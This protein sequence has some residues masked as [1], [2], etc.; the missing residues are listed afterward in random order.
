MPNLIVFVMKRIVIQLS[1][2]S[3]ENWQRIYCFIERCLGS[4]DYREDDFNTMKNNN[5][6]IGIDDDPKKYDVCSVKDEGIKELQYGA[7]PEK[8]DYVFNIIYVKTDE[9]EEFSDFTRFFL[10]KKKYSERITLGIDLSV[11][12]K[13]KFNDYKF[14]L[15]FFFFFIKN[16]QPKLGYN[17]L[18]IINIEG[19]ILKANAIPY[20]NDGNEPRYE[21][22]SPYIFP[23]I[24]INNNNFDIFETLDNPKD[25]RIKAYIENS[26]NNSQKKKELK[27]KHIDTSICRSLFEK[28]FLISYLTSDSKAK[29]T[30]IL[31]Y[32]DNIRELVQNIIFH[33]NEQ[34]G[35]LYIVFNKKNKVSK[36]WHDKILN[37]NTY[38]DNQRFVEI[39]VF[40]Y[41]KK[42]ITDTFSLS[43]NNDLF[44]ARLCLEDFLN[45][46]KILPDKADYISM[47]FAAHL[48]IKSFVSSVMYHKGVFCVESNKS[49]TEK[50]SIYNKERFENSE[51]K[52]I[53]LSSIS[54]I[55]G[56]HYEIILPPISKS[57]T[58][59][60]TSIGLQVTSV[61]DVLK[62]RLIGE[63]GNS[64]IKEIELEIKQYSE[65][66]IDNDHQSGGVEGENQTP[67]QKEEDVIKDYGKQILNIAGQYLKAGSTSVAINI[68]KSSIDIVSSNRFLKLLAYIQPLQ[69]HPGCLI[70]T[71]LEDEVI[72]CL[73]RL[74]DSFI[75]GITEKGQPIWS[76]NHPIVL[77]GKAGTT[78]IL[79]GK[80][81]EEMIYVNYGINLLYLTQ[82]SFPENENRGFIMPDKSRTSILDKL[83]VPYD[84][85]ICS[86]NSDLPTFISRV[87]NIL[88]EPI[89][90]GGMGCKVGVPTKIGSKLYVENYYEC[91]FLFQ[92]NFFTDRFAY[93]IAKEIIEKLNRNE[94]DFI[95]KKLVLIGYNP[96]S[97]PL[98]ERVKDY[99][100]EC[101]SGAITDIIIAKEKDKEKGLEFK[102]SKKQADSFLT[103]QYCFITIVPIASTLSTTDKIIA[104]FN[105]E[106]DDYHRKQQQKHSQSN[107]AK[108]DDPS[109]KFVYNH[110]TILVRDRI[111]NQPTNKEIGR[112]WKENGIERQ[113]IK[114]L[115]QRNGSEGIGIIVHYLIEREGLWCELINKD[116]DENEEIDKG[117]DGGGNEKKESMQQGTF[118]FKD[119]QNECYINK[120]KN[121]SLNTE[122]KFDLPIP[123]LPAIEA[124]TKEFSKSDD[125]DDERIMKEYYRVSEQRLSEIR[126]FIYFGHIVH[127]GSHH[128]YYFDIEQLF[129]A[130]S[131]FFH[132]SNPAEK[133]SNSVQQ[134]NIFDKQKT[135]SE[136]V[137]Y[138]YLCRW[139]DQIK[140]VAQNTLNIIITP[141]YDYESCYVSTI[142]QKVFGDNAFVVYLN[143]NDPLQ[144]NK[145]KLSYLKAISKQKEIKYYFVDQALL[146]GNTYHKTKSYMMSILGDDSFE[147]DSVITLINRLSKYKYKEIQQSLKS[148]HLISYL[149]F[150]VLPSKEME[151]NCSLCDLYDLY[152]NLK[153]YSVNE[154]CKREIER[155]KGK[156]CSQ[157]FSHYFDDSETNYNIDTK[158]RIKRISDSQ[159]YW[160]RMIWKHRL[161]FELGKMAEKGE[162]EDSEIAK[163][164]V[165]NFLLDLYT[166]DPQNENLDSKISF[167]KAITFP[168]LSQYVKVRYSAHRLQLIKLKELFEE[169][170]PNYNDLNLL[171]VLLKHLA[172]LGSNALVRKDVI[173]K[174][175]NLYFRVLESNQDKYDEII[176]KRFA[177]RYISY[178]KL[179]TYKDEAK[180]LWLG[181]LLRRG[182]EMTITEQMNEYKIQKTILYN[183]F[184]KVF[185][186][187]FDDNDD[188][189]KN[190]A[191]EF[192]EFFLPLL[193]YDNTAITRKTLDNFVLAIEKDL[194]LKTLFY[195]K[196]RLKGHWML[197]AFSVFSEN[198]NIINIVRYYKDRIE[199]EYYY[200]WFRHFLDNENKTP[201]G[202]SILEKF[203][204]VV[205][206]RL[207]LKDLVNPNTQNEKPFDQ[208][209]KDLLE[210][211][212]RV[213][214]ADAAFVIVKDENGTPYNL[215]SYKIE[216]N[217]KD[218]EK[219][220]Y[221]KLLFEQELPKKGQ[222]FIIKKEL[223]D[224]MEHSLGDGQFNR[225]SYLMLNM[226]TNSE[227]ENDGLSE[228]PLIGIVVFLFDDKDLRR[229]K[230]K[231]FL[232]EYNNKRSIKE[233][234][235]A[236]DRFMK[237]AQESGRLLLLLKPQ[238]DEYVKRV[239]DEKQ[240]E[241]WKE[242]QESIIR[243]EKVYSNSNHVFRSVF[244]E[245][246]EFE[247]LRN[248]LPDEWDNA[249]K[250]KIE[251][252]VLL[253]FSRTWYW[254]TNEM[255][256]YLYSNIEQHRR[257]GIHCLLLD[258][259]EPS[260]VNDDDTIKDVF[261]S[262]FI[263]MLNQMLKIR[264]NEQEIY[265]NGINI[266]QPRELSKLK[267]PIVKIHCNKF[268]MQT[269][270]TQCLNNSLRDAKD[271]GHRI[272]AR[273]KAFI[274]VSSTDIYIKDE[275]IEGEINTSTIIDEFEHK[276]PSIQSMDCAHYSCTTLTSL[277]GFV[278]YM[279]EQDC[280]N[281]FDCEF[282]F[283]GNNFYVRITFNK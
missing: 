82:S 267:I 200:A 61:S 162:K 264:W 152:K 67:K 238:I 180:S 239:A 219:Y 197:E 94:K 23:L 167:L 39:G 81:K 98:S 25:N 250:N 207:L 151:N 196:E 3:R 268:I 77:I 278:N 73:C 31:T 204:F 113:T 155:N 133:H 189:L 51:E 44:D 233:K 88:E 222:P 280:G 21:D 232:D 166:K 205:Y 114:T 60:T 227:L 50:N 157:E 5:I 26:I 161:Y 37:F 273:K 236:H 181:E 173:V 112:N 249:L 261:S 2:L 35:L 178:I 92:N 57:N 176:R 36:T 138:P 66:E 34:Q 125:L 28:W 258:K 224:D 78:R 188:R 186:H 187:V 70:F 215:A 117:K 100:N 141:D 124:I 221:H 40:D 54:N 271:G 20:M 16:K 191:K 103:G 110:V 49:Q 64:M 244:D 71:Q 246:A 134:L 165:F 275:T 10:L 130:V 182:E 263:S 83:I 245:M 22:A 276:K 29:A 121:A 69:N 135:K 212:A 102:M 241:V 209:A 283:E 259:N 240:F 216:N 156:F 183:S 257:N 52:I 228:G 104:L 95:E 149:H 170:N 202:I 65:S 32:C 164:R 199:H 277:Q 160:L 154:D 119:W 260:L 120:T 59:I 226:A 74:L 163:E 9:R 185:D 193:Y 53:E 231:E 6:E 198:D 184:F 243:F 255:I 262:C 203:V 46:Q 213:M 251:N 84:C 116:S 195:K 223:A 8:G 144:N 1:E 172:I 269:F 145:T 153:N 150:F 230:E 127:G 140:I 210:V 190:C 11:L 159:R 229:V 115:Y 146:T 43:H 122:E 272:C 177:Q 217:I 201:D 128:R 256:S 80:T 63:N 214:N 68:L 208:S 148:K 87:E 274:T 13:R 72:N 12:S 158:S 108:T 179:A 79:A 56:T 118:P 107:V 85:L 136:S 90:G 106:I 91:D 225:S 55:D 97:A 247:N 105:K 109:I 131:S 7:L 123:A 194:S 282:G 234:A 96:Y 281:L 17:S 47:R 4:K 48:G 93:F 218:D 24:P 242:K 19:S 45:P 89:V 174:S 15:G 14:Q 18:Y 254:L 220:Y 38:D 62:K 76:D 137:P 41:N 253:S 126:D 270:I 206:E 265:V 171:L 175:W 75:T 139:L 101:F 42:G 252:M 142:N 58:T 129:G 33:T 248:D 237:N 86:E 192:K 235:G 27:N 30:T 143:I 132:T 211:A 168:P 279:K 266:S 169:P 99:V 147:F 111:E